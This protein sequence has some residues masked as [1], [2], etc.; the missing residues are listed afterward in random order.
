MKTFDVWVMT[1]TADDP[2][3]DVLFEHPVAGQQWGIDR[4]AGNERHDYQ[5]VR[6]T[7]EAPDTAG[8]VPGPNE[9]QHLTFDGLNGT[10]TA[11]EV[12]VFARDNLHGFRILAGPVATT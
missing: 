5:T 11:S 10:L 6:Y 12:F 3:A 1:Q 4:G 9:R 2:P 7:I 8:I